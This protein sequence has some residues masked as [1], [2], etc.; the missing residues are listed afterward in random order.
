M[1]Q[2]VLCLILMLGQTDNLKITA[3]DVQIL[4]VMPSINNE[5][6]VIKKINLDKNGEMIDKWPGGFFE[7]GFKERFGF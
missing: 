1:M 2:F 6:S 7:E 3:D 4:F 5:G